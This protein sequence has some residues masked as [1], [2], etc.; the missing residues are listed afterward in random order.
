VEA[1]LLVRTGATKG[2]IYRLN[3]TK[4]RAGITAG[5]DEEDQTTGI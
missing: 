5:V 1:N 4:P 2:V 3:G